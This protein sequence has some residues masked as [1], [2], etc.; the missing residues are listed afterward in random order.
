MPAPADIRLAALFR[1]FLII[2]LTGF[3]GVLPVVVH[4]LVT[5]RKWMTAEDF[6]EILAIC[7]VLPGPNII[8]I[9]V[10]FGMRV[11]GWTG[12]MTA[13]SGLLLMPVVIALGLAT[14]YSEVSDLPRVQG[15]VNSIASAAAGLL[16]AA[17][18]QLLLP[19]RSN[20]VAWIVGAIVICAVIW[21]RVPLLWVIVTCGPLSILLTVWRA[22]RHA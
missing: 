22:G 1:C 20:P 15:A 7:Q 11:S 10:V 21:L 3:G 6:S 18:L 8:N 12:A 17:A 14:A 9:S 4:E 16:I 13:L 2:G 5:K 19:Q